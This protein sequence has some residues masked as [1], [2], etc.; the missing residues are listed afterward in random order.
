MYYSADYRVG[1]MDVDVND[2]IKPTEL[3][4]YLQET[5]NGQMHDRRPSYAE[6]FAEDKALIITRFS[7]EIY[8][9]IRQFDNINVRTWT[10]GEKGATLYRAYQVVRDD[11]CVALGTGDWAVVGVS[12]GHLYRTSEIDLSNYESGE[13]PELK[14]PSRF[15]FPKDVEFQD[16]GSYTVRLSDCD[17]NMHMNNTMY[18]DML[19][20]TIDD[21]MDRKVTS[22]NI[23]YRTEA[24]CGGDVHISKGMVPPEIAGDPNADAVFAFRT[25]TEGS[26]NVEALIGT[27][28]LDPES[29]TPL[30]KSI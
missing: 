12:D 10:C 14:I 1:C 18:H 9:E 5:A 28:K 15:R 8:D 25:E 29:H 17:M 20:N 22:I 30:Y 27:R 16:A 6:L 26:T 11:E 13:K 4:M 23:R 3:V 19:W 7:L 24:K 21:V 2:I